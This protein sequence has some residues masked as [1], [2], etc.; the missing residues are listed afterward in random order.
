MNVC[1]I[2][3]ITLSH[4]LNLMCHESAFLLGF[5]KGKNFQMEQYLEL[6]SLKYPPSFSLNVNAY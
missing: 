3:P 5:S 6:I 2:D 4:L 1:A